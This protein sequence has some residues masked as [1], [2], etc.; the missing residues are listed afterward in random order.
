MVNITGGSGYDDM[1]NVV[2]QSHSSKLRSET[3]STEEANTKAKEKSGGGD[4]RECIHD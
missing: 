3:R 1:G 4:G 2:E